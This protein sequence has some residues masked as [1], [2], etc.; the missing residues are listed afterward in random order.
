MGTPCFE[1]EKKFQESLWWRG[2]L[3]VIGKVYHT[4]GLG[5]I[6]DMDTMREAYFWCQEL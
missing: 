4:K 3:V 1:K 5:S 2:N 6:P